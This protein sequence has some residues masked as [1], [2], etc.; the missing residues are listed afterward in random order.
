MI[1]R[2][3][4]QDHSLSRGLGSP[5]TRGC[6][7][8][9][10]RGS[11]TCRPQ[12]QPGGPPT[13]DRKD[14]HVHGRPTPD[15]ARLRRCLRPRRSLAA[16]LAA[17]VLGIALFACVPARRRRLA[18]PRPGGL[19]HRLSSSAWSPSSRPT[20]APSTGGP[21]FW[22]L[23]LQVCLALFVLKFEIYG[24]EASAS[25]T[26][27]RPASASSTGSAGFIAHVPRLRHGGAQ[28]VFGV[29]RRPSK[30]S[31]ASSASDTRPV[32]A[33]TALPTI[34]FVSSF[35]TVLY[36]FGILQFIVR[37]FA[38]GMMVLMGTSGAETLSA[39]ANVFMGQT[40]APLIV[41]PYVAAHDA[42]GAARPHGRRHGDDLRRA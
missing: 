4:R 1:P 11:G 31:N 7:I 40:E 26:A 9:D 22:G 28:F 34:I 42:V 27:S 3:S 33:F 15:L 18:E 41:K 29:A 35:F 2:V 25:P 36:Y 38:R 10:K 8:G 16:A 14:S 32:F 20:C 12:P 21:I 6:R 5:L 19:R 13:L 30:T 24:L 17:A 37:V 23:A 39:V